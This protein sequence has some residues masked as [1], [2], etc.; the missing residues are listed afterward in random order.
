VGEVAYMIEGPLVLEL[1]AIGAF[2]TTLR[3][4]IPTHSAEVRT[5]LL[6]AK[7]PKKATVKFVR[8]EEEWSFTLDADSFI[9]R[10]LK[11]PETE[12]F[13]RIGKF[14][15]RMILLDTFHLIFFHFYQE[16][17]KERKKTSEW[18]ETVQSMRLW[19]KNRPMPI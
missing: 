14:Q 6:A 10:G 3:K 2:E 12:A 15:E 13:D 16:F 7:K 11:M 18:N 4:G 5:A 1:E 9:F 19:I 17:L 8:G